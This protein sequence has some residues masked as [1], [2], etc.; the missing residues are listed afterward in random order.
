M[1]K[2]C[3]YTAPNGD[4]VGAFREDALSL[5]DALAASACAP[6]FIFQIDAMMSDLLDGMRRQSADALLRKEIGSRLV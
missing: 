3:V 2:Q 5:S 1:E 4:D 6:N